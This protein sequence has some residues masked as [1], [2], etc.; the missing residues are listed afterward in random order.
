MSLRSLPSSR[1]HS[2]RRQPWPRAIVIGA[3]LAATAAFSY[4]QNI[5][6]EPEQTFIAAT[7]EYA[8]MHRGL[9]QAIGSIDINTPIESI[10]RMIQELAAAIRA[11]RPDARQGDLFTQAFA[12]EARVRISDALREHDF[13]PADVIAAGRVDGIDYGRVS[14]R[15]N[16]T[17]PW[18]LG[19]AMFPCLIEALPPLPPELQ[20]RMVGYDLVLIDV[21]ASLI[22]DILPSALADLTVRAF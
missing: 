17:F 2:G 21:H 20:Y 9:E 6:S 14:L 22:V 16:G 5:G 12:R 1:Q 11:A 19:V 18:I 3:V 8:Q 15:V 4:G 7:R 13:T 10:N